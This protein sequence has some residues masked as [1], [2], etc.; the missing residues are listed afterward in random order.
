VSVANGEAQAAMPYFTRAMQLGAV[1]TQVGCDRGLAYDL[2][3][4][5]AKAQADYRAALNGPDADEARRRLALSLAISGDKAGALQTLAPLSAKRDP[6]A[7][8][9]RAFVLAL[10]GD[11]NGAMVA[12]DAAMPGSWSRVAPFLQRLPAL[13]PD[14][15]AAAVNLG[16]F[17][18]SNGSALASAST[19]TVARYSA[20][21]VT[22]SSVTTDRLAGIDDLLRAP[23][24]PPQ[25]TWQPA[26][27]QA[28]PPVQ[29]AYAAP[30]KRPEAAA[31]QPRASKVWL[32]LASGSNAAA[33]PSQFQ[34][35]K[36]RSHDLFD[37]I[38]GYVARSP[39]RARLVIGPF[40]GTSDA[41]IFA[42]DLESVGVSSFRWT[43]SESDQIV[44]L[45]TE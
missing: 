40:R 6:A 26:P 45:G 12:I 13:R 43:N 24:P 25:P 36:S 44:P 9:V 20:G 35:I 33:L 18:D 11:S 32:Q 42:E 29:V 5:Q 7:G 1:Q 21:S 28:Q 2:L 38:K 34:R 8:R 17:P 31:A 14:Q 23:P 39:D 30:V 10:G 3:G 37:G 15:K 22:S 27:P 16:I 4:Q 19:P 41:Q